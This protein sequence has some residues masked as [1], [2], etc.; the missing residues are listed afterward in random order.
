M[1]RAAPVGLQARRLAAVEPKEAAIERIQAG[2][3]IEQGRFPG[4]VRA[5][6]PN[7]WPPETESDI[8]ER[9]DAAEALA[10]V[11][12]FEQR[13]HRAPP[14]G[15]P[16]RAASSL[17]LTAEGSRPPGR[18]IMTSTSAKP[19]MSMRITS[20]SMSILPKSCL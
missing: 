10:H 20:G 9:L 6:Q 3:Q 4:A 14:S 17:F 13:A 2:E 1:P 18:R 19:K 12:R 16:S 15:D 7:I 11:R 8:R 5:D